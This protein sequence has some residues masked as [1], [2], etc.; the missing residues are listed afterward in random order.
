MKQRSRPPALPPSIKD[1]RRSPIVDVTY[2]VVPEKHTLRAACWDFLLALSGF[3]LRLLWRGLLF[4][5][6]LAGYAAIFV[7]CL[8]IFGVL[9]ATI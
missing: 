8:L 7:A 6:I 5:L 9:F 3:C 4:L 1:D 2:R